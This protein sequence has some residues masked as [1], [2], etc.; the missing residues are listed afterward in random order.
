MDPVLLGIIRKTAVEGNLAQ[1]DDSC[2]F[3][4]RIIMSKEQNVRYFL[5]M[6]FSRLNNEFNLIDK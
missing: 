1:D 5:R 2:D 3:T 4:N 6:V